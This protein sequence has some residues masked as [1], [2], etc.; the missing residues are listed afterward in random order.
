M[1]HKAEVIRKGFPDLESLFS[2][3]NENI[4]KDYSKL[5]VSTIN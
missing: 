3:K 5:K 4:I 2:K 1:A